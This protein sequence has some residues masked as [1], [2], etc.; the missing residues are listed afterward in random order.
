MPRE[1]SSMTEDEVL[2]EM[3]RR[4]DPAYSTGEVAEWFDMSVETARNRLKAMR[5]AGK[6]VEKK[7][8]SRTQI[9]WPTEHQASD[10]WSL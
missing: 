7:P 9:W 1:V 4:G 6:V 5:D 10:E 3:L 2:E 8:S